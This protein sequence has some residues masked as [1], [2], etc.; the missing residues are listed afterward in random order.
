MA[1]V[2]VAGIPRCGKGLYLKKVA[3]PAMRREGRPVAVYDPMTAELKRFQA[4]AIWGSDWVFND[5]FECIE[6]MRHS[7]YC[8]F[9][10]DEV[11][12]ICEDYKA[13]QKLKFAAVAAGNYGN[14]GVFVAQRRTMI[15]PSIRNLCE[16]AILFAQVDEELVGLAKLFRQ[17]SV[18]DA[19]RFSKGQGMVVEPFK[20]PRYF[21]LR[22]DYPEA[23]PPD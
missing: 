13:A 12:L 5:L 19:A 17:P 4:R 15:P 3:I 22:R 8:T 10:F 14:L 2:L 23:F 16:S 11:G 20:Q 18:M 1:G 6:A 9:I 7:T 21:D